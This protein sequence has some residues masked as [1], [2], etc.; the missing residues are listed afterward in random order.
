[1]TFESPSGFEPGIPG[2]GI[3]RLNHWAIAPYLGK[4]WFVI[5][6]LNFHL[7][8][9]EIVPSAPSFTEL[10]RKNLARVSRQV[11]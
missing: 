5:I 2:L 8:L 7:I 6:A 11:G 3:Q 10:K 4:I 1:M 9:R